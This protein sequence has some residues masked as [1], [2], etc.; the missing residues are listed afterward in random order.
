MFSNEIH[1]IEAGSPATGDIVDVRRIDGKF[2]ARGFYHPH[3]LVAVRILTFDDVEIDPDFFKT[4]IRQAAELR[5]ILYP[6][7]NS[8]RLIYGE[9]DFLPGLIVDK[10]DTILS[11]QI[12]SAGM[13]L[14]LQTIVKILLEEFSPESMIEKNESFLRKLE[15]LP[16]RSGFLFGEKSSV[17]ITE[18]E[19]RYVIDV[20]GGQKTGFF[21]DQRE[22]RKAIRRYTKG[23]HVLDCFCN[24]G[25]FSLNSCYGGASNV[26]GIDVSDGAI[27]RARSNA[28]ENKM[29]S[30]CR[31]EVSDVFERL[32]KEVN[33]DAQFDVIILDPPSFTKSRKTV[34]TAK[35]GYK[36]INTAAMKI[37][38][39]GGILATASCSHHILEQTFLEIIRESAMAASKSIQLLEWHGAG[40]DHPV[41]PAMPETKYLKFGIFRIS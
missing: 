39:R 22:N 3:S 34:N 28:E 33:S 24:D 23:K 36:E 26:L 7:C 1:S 40:P 12:L 10:F 5:K 11:L 27:T 9:S 6:E 15:D 31:F 37:L 4:R 20:A 19:I 17:M 2:L 14:R 13:E 35:K 18:N 30:V 32:Q 21:L 41:L 8:Y 16:D 38:K 25:G 29:N